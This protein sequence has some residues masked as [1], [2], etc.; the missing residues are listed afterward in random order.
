MAAS[1]IPY[2]GPLVPTVGS[3]VLENI[4]DRKLDS[5]EQ[6]AEAAGLTSAIWSSIPGEA[7]DNVRE[8]AYQSRNEIWQSICVVQASC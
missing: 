5:A 4:K 3:Q 1:L 2:I 6:E 7:K 8:S